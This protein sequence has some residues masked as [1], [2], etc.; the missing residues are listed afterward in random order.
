MD[1]HD[2]KL[3]IEITKPI[4]MVGYTGRPLQDQTKLYAQVLFVEP[5]TD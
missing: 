1:N 5:P 2:W 3:H 4:L